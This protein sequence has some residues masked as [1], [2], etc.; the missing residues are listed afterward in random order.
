MNCRT[1]F[2]PCVDT[3]LPEPVKFAGRGQVIGSILGSLATTAFS[4]TYW[5]APHLF[6][7]LSTA[8]FRGIV[9]GAGPAGMVLGA[10][11]GAG[12][13]VIV[14]QS[15]KAPATVPVSHDS[16]LLLAHTSDDDYLEQEQDTSHRLV[17]HHK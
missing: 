16:E 6:K 1:F 17:F 11:I 5:A 9:F 15:G 12:V 8:A 14:M 7:E 4:I 10:A 2:N 13:G 3:S